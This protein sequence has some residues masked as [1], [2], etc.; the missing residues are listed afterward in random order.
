MTPPDDPDEETRASTDRN[1]L[2]HLQSDISPDLYRD[3]VGVVIG[4]Q[5]HIDSTY[6]TRRLLEEAFTAYCVELED[7]YNDGRRWAPATQITRGGIDPTARAVGKS[8]KPLQSWIE[9]GVRD[10]C[11]GTV[12]GMKKAAS[13]TFTLRDLVESALNRHIDHLRRTHNGFDWE[14]QDQPRRG[15]RGRPN[16][17]M[18]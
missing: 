5:D 15:R 1:G 3:A 11:Y 10:R 4:M 17:P 2:A 18:E 14:P 7:H 13:P 9:I 6:S 8:L 12:N 16:I